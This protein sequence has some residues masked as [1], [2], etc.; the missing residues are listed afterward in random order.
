MARCVAEVLHH[1]FDEAGSGWSE[2]WPRQSP[3][4]LLSI[5][6]IWSSRELLPLTA[7]RIWSPVSDHAALLTTFRVGTP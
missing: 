2:T 1:A 4:A 5:D 7:A 6:H 3:V